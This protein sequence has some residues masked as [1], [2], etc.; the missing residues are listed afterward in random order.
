MTGRAELGDR[1]AAS[2]A[3]VSVVIPCFDA[4]HFVADAVSSVLEQGEEHIEI[5]VVDDG[6]SDGRA[7]ARALRPFGRAVLR[8]DGPHEGLAATR[9][10]GI[11]AAR[12]RYLAFLDADDRWKP[13]FLARQ[14]ELLEG[15]GADLV[16]CDAE[17]FGPMAGR[18]GTVMTRHPSRGEVTVATVLAGECV[19]VMSTVVVRADLVRSVGGFDAELRLCEDVDLWVRLLLAGGRVAYHTDALALRRIHA[20]NISRDAE[21]MLRAGL[22]IIARYAGAAHLTDAERA[23]VVRRVHRIRTRLHVL[24]AK[25]AILAGR[26]DAARRELWDAFL[27]MRA[28]KP[29]AAALSLTVAPG[30][31]MRFLRNRSE[32]GDPRTQT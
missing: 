18:G 23:R 21:G 19:A 4:A 17:L 27:R 24:T 3:R 8:L 11:A 26:P 2:P 22:A 15:S 30:L 28:W 29:L 16:Y 32:Q 9:N 31:T 20:T 1:A 10:R 6:S 7:L 25:E 5:I 13:G 12:G 14:I